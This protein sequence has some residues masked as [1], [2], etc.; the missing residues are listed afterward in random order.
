LL[1]TAFILKSAS[2]SACT[3]Y[4][5]LLPLLIL[6]LLLIVR[7]RQLILLEILH[8]LAVND[9][10]F[11]YSSMIVGVL[12][13]PVVHLHAVLLGPLRVILKIMSK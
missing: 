10:L 13:L 11:L 7:L 12:H 6:V 9:S 4:L 8:L 3:A 2:T 5:A 1:L